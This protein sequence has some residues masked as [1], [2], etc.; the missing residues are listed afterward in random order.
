MRRALLSAPSWVLPGASLDLD[1]VHGR[2]WA[3][4][5]TSLAS[6]LSTSRASA[7]MA[8]FA[9]GTWASFAANVP[10]I[11]DQGILIEQGSTNAIRNN[12]MVGA[13]PGTPG[14]S[15]THWSVEWNS[16]GNG[17]TKQ[18]VGTGTEFGLPY[19]DYNISGTATS[20]SEAAIWFADLQVAGVSGQTWTNSWFIRLLSGTIPGGTAPRVFELG[21]NSSQVTQE[22][23]FS[24]FA[25]TSS[26]QRVSDTITLANAATTLV[27][28]GVQIFCPQ[29]TAVNFTVR[30]YA[31]Q[32]EQLGFA[33][34][35]ILTSGS[36]ATRAV[37]LVT[38]PNSAIGYIPNSLAGTVFSVTQ[39]LALSQANQSIVNFLPTTN[40]QSISYRAYFSSTY[41]GASYN[42]SV[43]TVENS[44]GATPP[45]VLRQLLTWTNSSLTLA[46]NGIKVTA[47]TS[48][49]FPSS[50]TGV[51]LG[52]FG[53]TG[54]LGLNG[55]MAHL[56]L[57][58]TIQNWPT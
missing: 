53:S 43:V 19:I 7:G 15:P 41:A 30:L 20:T 44:F 24:S 50:P 37:D 14:T 35:P 8:Q 32:L 26:F 22:S 18:L 16:T 47:S 23:H 45:N 1:F 17:V 34:S 49:G 48:N 29:G 27:Q 56:A 31:P 10:R 39:G 55:Y 4:G 51:L 12:S 52:T 46:S 54:A 38:L 9:N 6:L 42:G 3:G 58:K 25:L 21:A 5:S 33:T 28:G 36:V 11:T 2:A 13:V 57:S 40:G